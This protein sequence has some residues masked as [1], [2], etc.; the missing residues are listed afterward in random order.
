M[1]IKQQLKSIAI[2]YLNGVIGVFMFYPVILLT[3]ALLAFLA[4]IC[5]LVMVWVWNLV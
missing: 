1:S 3:A 5:W 4:R 2:D